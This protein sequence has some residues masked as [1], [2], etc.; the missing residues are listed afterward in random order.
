MCLHT[1][2]RVIMDRQE[3]TSPQFVMHYMIDERHLHSFV[4]RGVHQ[5]CAH[6]MLQPRCQS[7]GRM[8]T[9]HTTHTS[10][11]QHE[12]HGRHPCVISSHSCDIS[13][14]SYLNTRQTIPTCMCMNQEIQR[15]KRHTNACHTKPAHKSTHTSLLYTS[16]LY[17]QV[18]R[19]GDI[20]PFPLHT[21]Y[22]H[23]QTQQ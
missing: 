13:G 21:Q 3:Y 9:H 10:T 20:M 16:L 7:R 6:H 5:D 11:Q 15:G 4:M 12:Q 8:H 1:N 19:D 22:T 14:V 2:P 18:C 23:V 17:T